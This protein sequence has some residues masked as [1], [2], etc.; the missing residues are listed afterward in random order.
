MGSPAGEPGRDHDETPH[1]VVLTRGFWMSETEITQGQWE[2]VM[3]G[4]AFDHA[5]ARIAEPTL[6]NA[7][8]RG[9][10]TCLQWHGLTKADDLAAWH[11]WFGPSLPMMLVTYDD[12]VNFTKKMNQL[13]PVK[14]ILGPW[15]QGGVCRLPT[16]AEWE[17]ACRAGTTTATYA[18]ALEAAGENHVPV[19]SAIAWYKGNAAEGVTGPGWSAAKWI[20]MEVPGT[21][22]GIH[23][24][25]LKHPTGWGLRDMLGNV[26][27]WCLDHYRNEATDAEVNPFATID[28]ANR[29]IRGQSVISSAMSIRS[30]ARGGEPGN[31]RSLFRGFRIIL[32]DHEATETR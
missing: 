21:V 28:G 26:S 16:E 13:V 4:S 8:K 18:G 11:S 19:L 29:I 20:E 7:G 14:V 27:E 2:R 12:A 30:A 17:Y 32:L 15:Q 24:V 1:R 10:L 5:Q 6:F 25:G 9:Q 3:G 22:V 31:W 23:P